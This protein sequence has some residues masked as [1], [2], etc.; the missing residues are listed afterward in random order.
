M[1]SDGPRLSRPEYLA[2]HAGSRT[3]KKPL[4]SPMGFACCED[5]GR[6]CP[7]AVVP[8]RPDSSFAIQEEHANG[9]N[10]R[11]RTVGRNIIRRQTVSEAAATTVTIILICGQ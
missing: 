7:R 1:R 10:V 3:P 2:A 8:S 4:Q 11:A 5:F 9:R 6:T